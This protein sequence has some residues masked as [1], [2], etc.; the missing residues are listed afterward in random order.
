[1]AFNNFDW[2]IRL[3]CDV[4]AAEMKYARLRQKIKTEKFRFYIR[5]FRSPKKGEKKTARRRLSDAGA[6]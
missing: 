6:T 3:F 4:S 5:N 2:L 1:M